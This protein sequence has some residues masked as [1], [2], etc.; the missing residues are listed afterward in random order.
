MVN[1]IRMMD[2]TNNDNIPCVVPMTTL[3]V[4]RVPQV[5]VLVVINIL[6]YDIGSLWECHKARFRDC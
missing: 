1:V 6:F 2:Y 4:N 5:V 3:K